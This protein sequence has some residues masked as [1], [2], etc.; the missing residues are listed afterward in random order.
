MGPLP[1][2]VAIYL[3]IER[4]DET[5]MHCGSPQGTDDG[6][7]CAFLGRSEQLAHVEEHL[8]DAL[9]G[10][11]S[12]LLVE[13]EGGMGASRFIEEAQRR[14]LGTPSGHAECSSTGPAQSLALVAALDNAVCADEDLAALR[15]AFEELAS[16]HDAGSKG[17]HT[18]AFELLAAVVRR[19][20]GSAR[21]DPR[22]RRRHRRKAVHRFRRGCSHRLRPGRTR[23]HPTDVR[24]R[25]RRRGGSLTSPIRGGRRWA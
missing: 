10:R 12:V 19:Q 4:H 21:S 14:A 8:S 25:T 3:A 20:A 2:T 24:V 15:R 22:K 17:G 1:D 18:V 23:R 16:Q 13:G 5:L 9:S 11:F 7:A 6:S